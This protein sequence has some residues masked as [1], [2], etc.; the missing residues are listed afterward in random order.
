LEPN[1]AETKETTKHIIFTSEVEGLKQ[2]G[3]HHIF[4]NQP[5]HRSD[6]PFPCKR[7]NHWE[8]KDRENIK[9]FHFSKPNISIYIR[10]AKCL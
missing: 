9:R 3:T 4:E 5:F 8:P 6:Q 7:I 1:F 2:Q 10:K